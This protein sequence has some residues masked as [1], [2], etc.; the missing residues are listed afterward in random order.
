MVATSSLV[1]V[2]QGDPDIARVSKTTSR[3]LDRSAPARCEA[4]ASKNL[5]LSES[6]AH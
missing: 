6:A 2:R 3:V 4:I 1:V 5:G